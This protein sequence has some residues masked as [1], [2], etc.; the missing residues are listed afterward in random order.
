MKDACVYFPG[1]NIR[2]L[3]VF[4]QKGGQIGGRLLTERCGVNVGGVMT[5]SE[6]YG[7]NSQMLWKFR[8]SPRPNKPYE[9][10][11]RVE[12]LERLEQRA[13]D[14]GSQGVMPKDQKGEWH[15]SGWWD[16]AALRGQDQET[17]SQRRPVMSWYREGHKS[18]HIIDNFCKSRVLFLM[19]LF[20]FLILD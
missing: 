9:V 18:C 5:H 3:L 4:P 11:G 15:C 10:C 17:L 8:F 2:N 13:M 12:C 7:K 6:C 19:N 20:G 1:Q 14:S 16:P